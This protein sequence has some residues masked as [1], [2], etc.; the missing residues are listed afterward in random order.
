M[1][2]EELQRKKEEEAIQNEKQR[3][4]QLQQQQQQQ[5]QIR[6]PEQNTSNSDSRREG[7]QSN[8]EEKSRGVNSYQ[9]PREEHKVKILNRE[10]KQEDSV[11]VEE[12]NVVS[13]NVSANNGED[14]K[15]E[16][17]GRG[18]GQKFYGKKKG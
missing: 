7:K 11:H 1:E 18:V 17:K 9:N 16:K 14:Q 10:K 2:E 8:Q 12:G 5:Q 15:I 13:E 3:Q 6:K 4:Q